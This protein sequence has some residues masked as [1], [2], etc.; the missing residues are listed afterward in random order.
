MLAAE[1]TSTA[2]TAINALG[3]DLLRQTGKPT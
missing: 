1:P 3:I 2:A